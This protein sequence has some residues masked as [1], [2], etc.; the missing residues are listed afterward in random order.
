VRQAV[1]AWQREIT[2]LPSGL[3]FD[4]LTARAKR[5]ER[6]LR[7]EQIERA[8]RHIRTR[9][10]GAPMRTAARF[11]VEALIGLIR[12]RPGRSGGGLN[13]GSGF[14]LLLLFRAVGWAGV[15]AIVV[16]SLVPGDA[17]PNTGLPGQIDHIITYCGTAGILGLGYPAT[18]SRFGTMVMLISLAATLEVAQRWI[19][20]RHPQFIDFVA[21]VA[22][23]CLGMLAAMV[24]H[25][26]AL[27][28]IR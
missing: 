16:V 21:S 10:S 19:P 28:D 12:D 26:I 13:S 15:V 17:R 8:D 3:D 20:G 7:S 25:R 11:D 23:T 18:K 27:G 6:R 22:G 9:F 1:A 5:P 14:V 24:V 4:A 2:T